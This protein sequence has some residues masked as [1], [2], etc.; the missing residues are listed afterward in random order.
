MMAKRLPLPTIPTV[1]QFVLLEVG[2]TFLSLLGAIVRGL[3]PFFPKG[4]CG[5]ARCCIKITKK[6]GTFNKKVY[7]CTQ[8][9]EPLW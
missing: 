7:L 9:Y 3:S 6:F 8:K 2:T 4:T 1:K 5:V